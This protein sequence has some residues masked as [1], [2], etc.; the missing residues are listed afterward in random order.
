MKEKIKDYIR[1]Y[2]KGG[3]TLDEVADD[4]LLLFSV[5]KSANTEN[6]INV[7]DPNA[8]WNWKNSSEL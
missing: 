4:I 7:D 5:S 3:Y 2:V 1:Q 6:E 8:P